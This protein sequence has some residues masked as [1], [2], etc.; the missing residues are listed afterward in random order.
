MGGKFSRHAR[1]TVGA[2]RGSSITAGLQQESRE[3]E[4]EDGG[5][6]VTKTTAPRNEDQLS[7][8]GEQRGAVVVDGGA[9]ED[10]GTIIVHAVPAGLGA[11]PRSGRCQLLALVLVCRLG[12]SELFGIQRHQEALR[13]P[14]TLLVL[15]PLRQLRVGVDEVAL[16]QDAWA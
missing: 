13:Y 11:A 4:S 2:P 1:Q 8:P 14:K 16:V 9:A 12:R 10:H 6:A 5:H 3:R 7:F 15:H